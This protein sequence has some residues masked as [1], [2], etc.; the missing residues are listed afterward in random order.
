MSLILIDNPAQQTSALVREA[1][2]KSK[3]EAVR[4]QLRLIQRDIASAE[5][6]FLDYATADTLGRLLHQ[7]VRQLDE[8]TISVAVLERKG[9]AHDG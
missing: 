6:R 4:T 2:L 5:G 1:S 7:A 8:L 9:A 3:L